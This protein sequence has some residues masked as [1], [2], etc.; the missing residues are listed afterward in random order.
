[1]EMFVERMRQ[2]GS[3]Q[4]GHEG[5]PIR[6]STIQEYASAIRIYRSREA[7]QEV[8]PELAATWMPLALKHMRMEDGPP[9]TRKLSR[10][11]RAAHFAKLV[12]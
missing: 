11:F 2:C 6:A 12:A 9:S 1:M 5:E 3:V 7:R 10:A 4:P 8:V